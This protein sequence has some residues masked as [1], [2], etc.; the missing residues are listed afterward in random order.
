MPLRRR[1]TIAFVLAVGASAAALAAGSYFV[2]RHNLL[3]DSVKSASKQ[4]R[5]NLQLA[6]T[7]LPDNPNK[8]L[9]AY[10]GMGGFDT[11]GV[12]GGQ[13]FQSGFG[14]TLKQVPAGLRRLV[15]QGQLGYQRETVTGKHYVVVGGPAGGAELYFFFSEQGL[16][17]EL[18]LL[19]NILLAGGGLLVLL[20]ALAGAVLARQTLRPVARASAAASSLAE[21]LLETR[22]PVEGQD[23]FGAWAR[24]FNEMAAAL[25]TKIS[26]LSAAQARERRFTADVAHELRTPLTALVGEA[27]LLGEH[28]DRLPPQSRRP[29][30]LLIADVGRLRK[31]VEELMEISR[32]DAGA[33]SVHAEPVDLVA[34][35]AAILGRRGWD[36]RVRLDGEETVVTT[37]PRRLERIVANLVGNALEHGGDGVVVRVGRNGSHAFVEVADKGPGIPSEHLPHLFDRFY[38]ADPSRS[39]PGSGLGLAIAQENAR[40]LGGEIQVWSEP[41]KGSRFTLRL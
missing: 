11:V 41:G 5:R 7:Y 23:E 25:E 18:A 34:V 27:S 13:P 36:G 8:L 4:S 21:G 29:A 20:A 35:T 38:K 31:L 3:A 14:A 16:R 30:E 1:L 19:R 37:D 10:R 6:P 24:A 22:L 2:V 9:A 26:A 33:E 39:G 12:D 40:L 28:L 17:H 32:L 15:K